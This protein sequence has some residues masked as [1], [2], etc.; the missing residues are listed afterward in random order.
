[1]EI[2]VVTGYPLFYL[3]LIRMQKYYSHSMEVTILS[4]QTILISLPLPFFPVFKERHQ[5]SAQDSPFFMH[6]VPAGD[7]D[8]CSMR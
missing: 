2:Y 4:A 5:H 7:R 1:M 6:Q 8:F 3:L